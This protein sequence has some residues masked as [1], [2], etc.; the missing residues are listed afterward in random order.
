M[1]NFK[2]CLRFPVYKNNAFRDPGNANFEFGVK[3]SH[4]HVWSVVI[5]FLITMVACCAGDNSVHDQWSHHQLD[6]RGA[7]RWPPTSRLVRTRRPR[8]IKSKTKHVILVQGLRRRRMT[9][10]T[11]FDAVIFITL[12]QWSMH[13]LSVGHFQRGEWVCWSENCCAC[14][15]TRVLP[16]V[17]FAMRLACNASHEILWMFW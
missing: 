13:N 12:R 3:N 7:Q 15:I 2:I 16:C 4:S 14:C 8:T 9:L 1:R 17:A 6:G 5:K 10:Q 11:R